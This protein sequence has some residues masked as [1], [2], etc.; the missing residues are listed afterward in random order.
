M[1]TTKRLQEL[2]EKS[3]LE[4]DE[5]YGNNQV[6]NA[7]VE[8]FNRLVKNLNE[9]TETKPHDPK[10]CQCGYCRQYRLRNR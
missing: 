6:D 3:R 9:E 4:A 1:L 2:I 10:T 8:Y 5:L 7:D